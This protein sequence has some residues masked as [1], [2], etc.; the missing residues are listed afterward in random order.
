[1]SNKMK[2]GDFIARFAAISTDDDEHVTK[3]SETK[4]VKFEDFDMIRTIGTYLSVLFT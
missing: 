4:P 1:M 3:K 2:S